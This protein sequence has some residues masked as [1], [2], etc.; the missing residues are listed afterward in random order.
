MKHVITTFLPRFIEFG[1]YKDNL[2]GTSLES[3]RSVLDRS[4]VCLVDV[5]AEVSAHGTASSSGEGFDLRSKHV[6][7]M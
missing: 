1:E 4:K 7:D 3:I 2:Y 5:H 6:A